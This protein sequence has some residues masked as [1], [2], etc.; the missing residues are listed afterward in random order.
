MGG[1]F[2]T[3]TTLWGNSKTGGLVA[4]NLYNRYLRAL[5]MAPFANAQ[6]HSPRCLWR[7]PVE[8][9]MWFFIALSWWLFQWLFLVP[10][11]G[12][13]W[14]IIPQF[15]VYTTYILPSGGL[16]YA[17]YHLLR[18]PETTIDF[19]KTCLYKAM[20]YKTS[21]AKGTTHK[22]YA[23]GL[24]KSWALWAIL[25]YCSEINQ[26]PRTLLWGPIFYFLRCSNIIPMH[27]LHLFTSARSCSLLHFTVCLTYKILQDTRLFKTSTFFSPFEGAQKQRWSNYRHTEC[28]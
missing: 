5:V 2:L 14:H 26:W 1:D 6:S 7:S 4:M 8:G 3:I 19:P 13:R 12:G 23:E 18:E 25:M 17:T 27:V 22:W 21:A 10:V 24:R 16:Y 9:V 20:T 28:W 11:K 15:A